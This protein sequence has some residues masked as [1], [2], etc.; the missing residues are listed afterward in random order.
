M[1]YNPADQAVGALR[2]LLTNLHR[3]ERLDTPWTRELLRAHGR[4]PATDA[5]VGAVTAKFLTEKISELKDSSDGTWAQ[6]LPHAVLET[7]FVE[8]HKSSQAAQ[9]LGV[10]ERQLSRER[11]RALRLLAAK[12]APPASTRVSQDPI[13]KTHGHIQ[14]DALVHRL[15]SVIAQER[16]VAVTG[17]PG[18]GKTSVVAALARL[19]RGGLVWWVRIRPGLND[20]L[21]SLLFEL[22]RALALEG[23]APLRDYLLGTLP[24]PDLRTATRLALDG[25]AQRPRLIVID[26]FDRAREPQ[27]IREFLQEAAERVTDLSVVTIGTVVTGGAVVDVPALSREE[28]E[29]LIRAKGVSCP[30]KC[31]DALGDLTTRHS[32]MLVA[33][34]SWWAGQ[35]GARRELQRQVANRGAFPHLR[36]IV[37]FVW[38]GAA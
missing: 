9:E 31:L 26:D 21:E 17:S 25:I 4:L 16:F 36:G 12:L 13:P 7:C 28:V 32:G 19:V 10:S 24:R 35:P 11:T 30:G 27:A 33:T 37:R 8:G 34:G 23:F 2:N 1:H 5:A 29:S 15:A 22:G 14:R 38:R 6:R 18:A 3:P 20:C